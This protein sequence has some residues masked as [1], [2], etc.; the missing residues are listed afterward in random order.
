M[1]LNDNC[2]YIHV[3]K[4]NNSTKRRE[5]DLLKYFEDQPAVSNIISRRYHTMWD[6]DEAIT[7]IDLTLCY[8]IQLSNVSKQ[9]PANILLTIPDKRTP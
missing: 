1:V 6:S 7:W 5:T 8:Q 2:V 4:H 3:S 9:D